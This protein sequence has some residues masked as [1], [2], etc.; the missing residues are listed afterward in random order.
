MAIHPAIRVFLFGEGAGTPCVDARPGRMNDF[1]RRCWVQRS[2]PG[3][4]SVFAVGRVSFGRSVP[5]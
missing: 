1:L 4:H 2:S 5:S 3:K